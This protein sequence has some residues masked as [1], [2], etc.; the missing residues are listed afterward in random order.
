MFGARWVDFRPL[1]GL[2]ATICTLVAATEPGDTVYSISPADGGHFA[3]APL[4][5]RLARVPRELPWDPASG[6]IDVEEFAVVWRRHP[7]RMVFL[8]HSVPQRP[9]P[10]AALRAVLGTDALLVYDASHTLGLVAGG[11][12]QNPLAEGCDILQGNTHKSFPGAHKGLLAFREEALGR[13]IS[14]AMGEALV[15]SQATGGTLANFVT[16]LE[17][18]RHGRDY[19]RAMLVNARAFAE[20]LGERGLP[21]REPAGAYSHVLLIDAVDDE[22]ALELGRRLLAAGI[23]VNVRPC[24]GR[25]AVR[26]GVQEVTRLGLGPTDLVRLADLISALARG[27]DPQDAQAPVAALRAEFPL[28]RYSLEEPFDVEVDAAVGGAGAEPAMLAEAS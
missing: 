19:A 9:L 17:L 14:A 20:S 24:G 27:A 8:D 1:S 15:S 2:H 7:G 3:T 5:R 18:D 10:V 21:V 16:C 11:V 22:A 6:T 25:M 26:L 4:L 28:V 12:F 13:R 23:R